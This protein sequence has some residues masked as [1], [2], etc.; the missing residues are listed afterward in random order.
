MTAQS[1]TFWPLNGQVDPQ[2]QQTNR[3]PAGWRVADSVG[4]AVGQTSIRLAVDPAG[5]LGFTWPDD[6]LGGLVLPQGMALTGDGIVYLWSQ[7]QG[8]IQ[9]FNPA[10]RRFEV[11]PGLDVAGTGARQFSGPLGLAVLGRDLV[12]ADAGSGRVQVFALNSLTLRHVWGPLDAQGGSVRPGDTAHGLPWRP[13]DVATDGRHIYV[14]D[15]RH[16]RLYQARAG[17]EALYPFLKAKVAGWTWRRV[18]VDQAGRIYVEARSLPLAGPP[19]V[20]LE[21]YT[22]DGDLI[23]TVQDPG[24]V[25]D[26]FDPPALRL[27]YPDAAT[28]TE[29]GLFC[30]PLDLT[31]LCDR[32]SAPAPLEHPL[33]ACLPPPPPPTT[34]TAYEWRARDLLAPERMVQRLQAG[35]DGL[36]HAIRSRL[37]AADRAQLDALPPTSVDDETRQI[38][39]RLLNLLLAAPDL[40]AESTTP[41]GG[42][43]R[44]SPLPPLWPPSAGARSL[45]TP[46]RSASARAGQE[47]VALARQNRLL[48]E[49][50]YPEALAVSPYTAPGPLVFTREGDP[51]SVD[52]TEVGRPLYQRRGWWVSQALDSREYRCQW[53]RIELDLGDF[54]PGARIAVSTYTAGQDG[55]PPNPADTRLWQPCGALAAPMQAPPA[56]RQEPGAADDVVPDFLVQSRKGRYLWLK[57]ELEGDG[58]TSPSITGLRVHYPRQSYLGY[59][60][61]VFSDD[62][63][64]R[65]F[66]E[67]FLSVFQREWDSLD[68]NLDSIA[69]LFDPAAAPAD[70]RFLDVLAA[71]LGLPLE[72]TWTPQQK[73]NLL[74]AV[75]QYYRQ[76]GTVAGVRTFLRAY[77]L[78]MTDLTADEQNCFPGYPALLEGFHERRRLLL[79][80]AE[81]AELGRAS[82]LWG[83]SVVGRLQLG[84]FA[85]PGQVRLVSTGDPQRDLFHAFAHRFRVYVPS[86]WVRTA[87][88]E[89]M[90][91][92]ALDA[93]KPAHTSYDL[94]LVEPRF[95]VGIQSTVGLD[96]IIGGYPVT[97]LAC[98]ESTAPPSQPPRSRLG[99][100]TVL[101]GQPPEPLR[102]TPAT[103]IGLDTTLR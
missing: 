29:R 18:A 58:H 32:R 23:E 11:V 31:R 100:D 51:A 45:T 13:S 84:S 25:R 8:A 102:V 20:H 96:T 33:R 3:G 78:N 10:T 70:A 35:C 63:E 47:A 24:Q 34:A 65:W 56:G 7:R 37:T 44:P 12:V 95:R 53:H 41:V 69:R 91:R 94:C 90:L 22:P 42:A 55:P 21:V 97:R 71:W 88:D 2:V 93:E 4:V 28:P 79:A 57:L 26:R 87:S 92:R 80:P 103:R 81:A 27:F 5:P 77:L 64:S 38:L 54:P 82:R 17:A 101:S 59:L 85:Q 49:R 16:Q 48:L 40:A 66:L 76:R 6:S 15:S 52:P 9:R 1:P 60:P 36:S 61:R 19:L 30:L 83:P 73:S 46:R 68:E 39:L 74:Q 67:R 75:P 89:R 98:L 14:L 43:A 86:A 50:A 99:Y 72:A 62:D